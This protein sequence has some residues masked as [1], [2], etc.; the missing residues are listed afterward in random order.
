M[1]P[2]QYV[3]IANYLCYQCDFRPRPGWNDDCI[4]CSKYDRPTHI[5]HCIVGSCNGVTVCD[6]VFTS[7]YRPT[8]VTKTDDL[9]YH[10]GVYGRFIDSTWKCNMTLIAGMKF[11]SNA[12]SR[13]NSL[14]S[15]GTLGNKRLSLTKYR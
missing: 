10:V 12:S 5:F 7:N 1:W 9:R 11:L 3:I 2:L 13:R 14:F 4:G 15:I 8:R 6:V